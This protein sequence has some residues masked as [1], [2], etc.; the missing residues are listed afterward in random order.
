MWRQIYTIQYNVRYQRS[1][2]TLGRRMTQAALELQVEFGFLPNPSNNHLLSC[3]CTSKSRLSLRQESLAHMSARYMV[4]LFKL[5][6]TIKRGFSVFR[7]I[8]YSRIYDNT[9]TAVTIV[10]V[11]NP[12]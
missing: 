6:T 3:A 9:C 7:C 1:M 12:G 5:L 4:L 11:G 8:V 2:G 10:F